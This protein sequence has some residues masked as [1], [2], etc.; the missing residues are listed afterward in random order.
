MESNSF[1]ARIPSSNR[2]EMYSSFRGRCCPNFPTIFFHTGRRHWRIPQV[3]VV[4]SLATS[5]CRCQCREVFG[6]F[7]SCRLMVWVNIAAFT[8]Y[9]IL[10]FISCSIA[11]YAAL[12]FQFRNV[13]HIPP[14]FSVRGKLNPREA[15]RDPVGTIFGGILLLIC[16]TLVVVLSF[17]HVEIWEIV[18]PFTVTKFI[19]DHYRFTSIARILGWLPN[20][21]KRI[22]YLL[23]WKR[24]YLFLEY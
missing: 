4:E 19:F 9:T 6:A 5:W 22:E 15:L 18:L 20:Y 11:C 21:H 8:A 12:V 10:P 23:K 14:S 16:L 24:R 17:F 3:R 2:K 13:K 7:D 1:L